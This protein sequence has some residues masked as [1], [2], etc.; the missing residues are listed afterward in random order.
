METT[1]TFPDID[2]KDIGKHIFKGGW[3]EGEINRLEIIT[4]TEGDQYGNPGDQNLRLV[5]LLDTAD[6]KQ[7][8]DERFQ[9]QGAGAWKCAMVSK[10][11]GIRKGSDLTAYHGA[12]VRMEFKD[13]REGT[14][15][16]TFS[17]LARIALADG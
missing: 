2:P 17:S 1:T 12:K 3:Y 14:D 15:G 6:G 11:L 13:P 5:V 8:F 16:R 7:Q 9:F 10:G 4:V